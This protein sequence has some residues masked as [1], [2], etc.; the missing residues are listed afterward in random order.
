M[1]I[2][3]AS[4]FFI[5]GITG[6]SLSSNE[7]TFLKNNSLG[8]IILFKRNIESMEQ[9]IALNTSIIESSDDPPLI[10]VDQEGGRVAR[11]RGICTDL[12][13]ARK[14]AEA[15]LKDP[16]LAYRIGA[17]QARE[18][19]TL[20]FNL[21]FAPVCDV[22]NHDENE[23]IGDRAFSNDANTV[24]LFSS[25]YI[26]GL[27]EAGVAACAKHFPG[28]GATSVD[29]HLALPILDT[30]V[31]T[32]WSRELIPFKSAI[33]AN[34]ATIMTAHIITSSLDSLPATMSEKT[35]DFLL[36]KELSFRNVVI[37]DDLDMKAVADNYSLTEILYESMRASVDFFIVGND[38][39]K[40][41]D[42]IGVL[43]NLIDHD[44]NIRECATRA[45]LRIARL[46]ERFVGKP[47]SPEL[48]EALAIV[49]S[50]PHLELVK[51]CS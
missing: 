48:S 1:R 22:M 41:E 24:A 12:P 18:L 34:V 37:S 7:Q 11:L 50:K 19:A 13:P 42:A 38:L 15:F 21:N 6:P 31:N 32:L 35:L 30:D 14:L 28:H 43:Q 20:G 17:L 9:L 4:E 16:H 3:K 2:K 26:K 47:K 49:A 33:S 45:S 23:V 39:K 40:T 8:G 44:E 51:S 46:R 5:T 36:R 10:S 25:H 27:Q 29:S